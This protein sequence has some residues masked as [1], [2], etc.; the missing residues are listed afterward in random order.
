MHCMCT[1][2]L[3][4]ELFIAQSHALIESAKEKEVGE[5]HSLV[6]EAFLIRE[7]QMKLRLKSSPK[8]ETRQIE[9]LLFFF[10]WRLLKGRWGSS[11]TV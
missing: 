8:K 4:S 5:R 11:A 7:G 9:P 1:M 6:L 10:V 2:L 3:K